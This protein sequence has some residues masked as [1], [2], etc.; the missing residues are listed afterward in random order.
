MIKVI[1]V[2]T[3]DY[4][5]TLEIS[6]HSFKCLEYPW[7]NLHSHYRSLEDL[8]EMGINEILENI[9]PVPAYESILRAEWIKSETQKILG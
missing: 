7:I 1:A 4:K 8:E 6:G 2:E 9:C 5:F 3:D